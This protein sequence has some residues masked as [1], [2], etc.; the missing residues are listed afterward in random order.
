MANKKFS[1]LDALATTPALADVIAI[2]DDNEG[3]VKKITRG[4][5]LDGGP[6]SVTDLAVSGTY[7]P[8]KYN[9]F[10]VPAKEFIPTTTNGA[11]QGSFEWPNNDIMVYYY[12]FDDAVLEKVQFAMPMPLDWDRA[13]KFKAKFCWSSATGS[14][15]GDTVE[16]GLKIGAKGNNHVLDA[17]LGTE[18]VISDVLL[19]DDGAKMQVSE[20]TPDITVGGGT[21]ALCEPLF[22]EGFR[23]VGGTDDMLEDAWLFGIFIQYLCSNAVA[24][25]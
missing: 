3:L 1:E 13:S 16:W 12:A 5:F 14:T 15:A 17:A 7:T 24:T 18:Q 20:A 11:A 6:I 22:F 10:Y 21:V 2:L 19:A 9:T 25:W 23:N 8:H 4:N